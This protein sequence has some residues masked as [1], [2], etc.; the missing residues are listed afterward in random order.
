M[1]R[2]DNLSFIILVG[3]L[4]AGGFLSWTTFGL[5]S[6]DTNL[7]FAVSDCPII[8]NGTE[9]K[10]GECP[11]IKTIENEG[12]R[13]GGGERSTSASN[14]GISSEQTS[15]PNDRIVTEQSETSTP[16]TSGLVNPFGP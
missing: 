10:S 16:M 13:V 5:A 12:Q 1:V 2:K 4:L 15:T 8:G 3:T 7:Q 14:D 9:E 6:A 11:N